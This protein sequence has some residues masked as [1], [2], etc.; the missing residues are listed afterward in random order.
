MIDWISLDDV[1]YRWDGQQIVCETDVGYSFPMEGHRLDG[2]ELYDGMENISGRLFVDF[3]DGSINYEPLDKQESTA[4]LHYSV[5]GCE[6]HTCLSVLP[7]SA[8]LNDIIIADD[9]DTDLWTSIAHTSQAHPEIPF[10]GSLVEHASVLDHA[11]D[12]LELVLQNIGDQEP[13]QTPSMPVD[14]SYE[15]IETIYFDTSIP[16]PFDMLANI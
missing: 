4:V 15:G 12:T 3:I 9:S 11:D 7:P 10:S 13:L 6:Q 2:L 5:D 14:P 16:D 8:T 1:L